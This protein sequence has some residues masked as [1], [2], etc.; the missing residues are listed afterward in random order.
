MAQPICY[1]ALILCS[2]LRVVDEQ[3]EQVHGVRQVVLVIVFSDAEQDWRH[4]ITMGRCELHHELAAEEF[5]TERLKDDVRSERLLGPVG[6]GSQALDVL[7]HTEPVGIVV[8]D[9]LMH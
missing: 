3:L 6:S 5:S 9:L 8:P 4:E 1:S 2:K 7:A